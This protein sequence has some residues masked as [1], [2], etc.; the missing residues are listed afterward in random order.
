MFFLHPSYWKQNVCLLFYWVIRIQRPSKDLQPQKMAVAELLFWSSGRRWGRGSASAHMWGVHG[1]DRDFHW[2]VT[3]PL[4][5]HTSTRE[6]GAAG[7]AGWTAQVRI[8]SL[9]VWVR[10]QTSKDDFQSIRWF[11]DGWRA[12]S[13]MENTWMEGMTTQSLKLCSKND[14]CGMKP[15]WALL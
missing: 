8:T 5:Q 9:V 4:K 13:W 1:S 6:T 12:F 15:W 14:A 11:L 3:T 10:P 2:Q 7:W